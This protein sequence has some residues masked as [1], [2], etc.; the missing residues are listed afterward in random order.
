MK[1]RIFVIKVLRYIAIILFLLSI[2]V[3]VIKKWHSFAE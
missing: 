3:A 1:N 2:L